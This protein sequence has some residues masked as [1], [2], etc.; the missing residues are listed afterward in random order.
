LTYVKISAMIDKIIRSFIKTRFV[1]RSI[2]SV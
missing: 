2:S 1:P